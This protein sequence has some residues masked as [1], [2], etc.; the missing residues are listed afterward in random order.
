MRLVAER[1]ERRLKNPIRELV[2]E[3]VLFVQN[4]ADPIQMQVFTQN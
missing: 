3:Q 4:P 1:L 2:Q